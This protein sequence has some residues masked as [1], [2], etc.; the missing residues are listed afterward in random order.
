MKEEMVMKKIR[1][2]FKKV[3]LEEQK[4]AQLLTPAGRMIASLGASWRDRE[5]KRQEA[6]PSLTAEERGQERKN[7]GLK[8]RFAE[9]TKPAAKP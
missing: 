9:G 3:K 7:A 6:N 4:Q 2:T 8:V 5:E 1:R